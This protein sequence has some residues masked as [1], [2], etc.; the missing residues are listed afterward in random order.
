MANY[1]KKYTEAKKQVEALK[2]YE[3]SEAVSLLKKVNYAKFDA[4]VN[5]AIKTN[6]NP[7]YNDQMLRATTILPHGT[8]KKVRVAVFVSEDKVAEAKKAG[9][10]LAGF[11]SILTAIKSGK[12]DF[13]VL[14]TTPDHIRDLAPV[15]KQ[16]GPKGLMPSPK[17]GT[18]AMDIVQAVEE[19][20][21]GKIEFRLDK[22]GNIHAGVGKISFKEDQLVEN[23][24]ALMKAVEENKPSGV[25][26]KLV[27]KVV[28]S[29]TMSPG[30]LINY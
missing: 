17:A 14:I 25:K 6:A 1:G 20:K 30:I 24:Q 23:I 26:G 3:L 21:K 22:T 15:A 7:K 13:D 29:T 10:D 11:E 8:G 27:K 12:M 28:I 5:V 9:A 2:Q 4:T 18:V 16:L 19:V